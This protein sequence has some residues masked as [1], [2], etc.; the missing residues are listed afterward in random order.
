MS[1]STIGTASFRKG[2]IHY[3]YYYYVTFGRLYPYFRTHESTT[4]QEESLLFCVRRYST[5]VYVNVHIHT[6]NV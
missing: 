3:Y 1:V 5:S 2:C 6:E 4:Q